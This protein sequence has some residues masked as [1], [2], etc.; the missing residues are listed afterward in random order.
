MTR[1]DASKGAETALVKVLVSCGRGSASFVP[2][3]PAH[4]PQSALQTSNPISGVKYIIY[5]NALYKV[6]KVSITTTSMNS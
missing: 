5:Y 1:E 4:G 6:Y 3:P 2:A